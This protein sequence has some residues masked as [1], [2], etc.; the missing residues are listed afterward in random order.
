MRKHNTFT[1]YLKKQFLSANDLIESYFNK[2]KFNKSNLKK[3]KFI[4]HYKAF[5]IFGIIFISISSYFLLPSFYNKDLIQAQIEN[6]ISKKYNINIKINDKIN[7]RLLPRPHFSTT[8][9]SIYIENKNIAEIENFKIYISYKNFFDLNK[10]QVK[11]LVL[12]KTNFSINNQDLIFFENL[13]KTEPNENKILIKDSKIFFKGENDELLFINKIN[14][15]EFYYDPKNLLNTLLSSNE[16]FN[17]PFKLIIKNDKFNKK[18]YSEFKSRKIRLSIDNEIDYT[19]QIKNGFLDILLVNK[20]LSLDYKIKKNSLDFS[21][22]DNKNDFKGKM[23]FKPFYL[24]AD[25]HYDGLSSKNFFN[26]DSIFFDLIKSEIFNNSNLNINVNLNVKDIVNI[27]QLNDLKLKILIEEGNII[28]SDSSI[29]WK[30]DLKI[31]LKECLINYDNDDI[32]LVGKV[33][34][35]IKNSDNFFTSFQIKKNLRKKIDKIKFDLN[36]NFTNK[37]VSFYNVEINDNLNLELENFLSKFN[38]RSKRVFNK[39]TFRNFI[40]KFFEAYSG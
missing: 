15:Y 29:N 33:I 6:Q 25:F 26:E 35:D 38:S 21:T 23:D 22:N 30:K 28:L 10:I 31:I 40:N 17:V 34:I 39:I 36:Y 16:I 27:D 1:K 12:K 13:L 20:S 37:D 8:K 24:H 18:L 11:D 2:F 5:L 32:Y 19:E 3:T 7:Y 9:S 14:N 4:E